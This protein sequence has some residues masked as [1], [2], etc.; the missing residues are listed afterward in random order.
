MFVKNSENR[1]RQRGYEGAP[2]R[3][4][5]WVVWQ[6]IKV[7][8]QW[9]FLLQTLPFVSSLRILLLVPTMLTSVIT[10]SRPFRS[11]LIFSRG[12]RVKSHDSVIW[13]GDFNYRVDLPYEVVKDEVLK[14]NL[15]G[16]F[17]KDQ[18]N[19][20]MVKG[21]T[22]PYYNE[23]QITFPPTYKFD[24][25][26]DEYD[27]SEKMRTPSWTD[28]I[29]SRGPNL[30]QTSYGSDSSLKF[31]KRP[32]TCLCYVPGFYSYCWWRSQSQ[33]FKETLWS[34]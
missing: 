17:E 18:L 32:Q 1:Q 13:L 31:C 5:V 28:R 8:L 10:I 29:L 33:T 20:Q 12:R 30:H 21:E 34:A 16:L 7:V 25:D 3:R 9:V 22:F 4:P 19:L 27:T 11:G 6:A 2:Q 24:N 26:S 15:E 14:G 23:M